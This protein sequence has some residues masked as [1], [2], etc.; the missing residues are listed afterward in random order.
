MPSQRTMALRT[1]LEAQGPGQSLLDYAVSNSPVIFYIA[2]VGGLQPLKFISSNV[3]A[4]TGHEPEMFLN[5]VGAR[6][7]LIHPEDLSAFREAVNGL[8]ARRPVFETFSLEYRFLCTDGNYLWFRDELT[9]S[10]TEDGSTQVVGCM[11]D[12]TA[13]KESQAA[14]ERSEQRFQFIVEGSPLPVVVTDVKTGE[15]IYESPAG[16]E[17]LGRNGGENTTSLAFDHYGDVED[18]K[19]LM[20]I[21]RRDGEVRDFDMVIRK[22]DGT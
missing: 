3:E 22:V 16:A 1:A 5:T 12:I 14:L 20:E 9:M 2:E 10:L 15:F 6:R 13:E 19:H 8:K 7:N 21:L 11:I 4:I 18:G 17:V